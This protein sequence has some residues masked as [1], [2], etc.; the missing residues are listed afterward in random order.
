MAKG[1]T[2]SER[3][4]A[5][6]QGN[7]AFVSSQEICSELQISRAAVWKQIQ[8]L[9]R[10]G[11][12]IQGVSSM[13]YRLSQVPDALRVLALTP[14]IETQRLGKQIIVKEQTSSTND[15]LW[16]LGQ[17]GAQ[18][19]TVVMAEEQQAGKGRRGRQWVSPSG[20]NLYMSILLRPPLLPAEA[21]LITLMAAVALCE[22]LRDV[23]Q[24]QPQ[25][26]WPNDVL[27]AGRKT[28]GI[29]AEMHAEQ[30]CI[31]FLVL[32]IGVNLNMSPEMFPEEIKYPA[33]SL[34]IVLGRP[35][36]RVEFARRLLEYLD[37]G[38]DR[39]LDNGAAL[40]RTK[41]MDFCAHMD[42]VIDV[43][44][45]QGILRGRCVAI[46]EEGALILKISSEKEKKIRAGDVIRVST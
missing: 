3:I 28:A 46:D 18:E 38:Y 42:Q 2:Q 40:V 36:K 7:K 39:F 14:G 9:R 16:Q 45:T 44:T 6:L 27:L 30:E 11:Y 22:A 4:L 5:L 13:G 10:Q 32:G 25:I 12:D 33:T 37:Q 1:K 20:R 23:F 31:H 35:V 15:D 24:Q 21:S 17:Q 19:G 43:N 41:W 29:L 26:K 8:Q 34:Q